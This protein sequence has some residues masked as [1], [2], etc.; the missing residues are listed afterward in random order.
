MIQHKTSLLLTALFITLQVS[1]MEAQQL[2]QFAL[3]PWSL[4]EM[5]PAATG[6]GEDLIFNGA[7]RRQWNALPGSPSGYHINA[8]MP[9][10]AIRSGLGISLVQDQIGLLNNLEATVL[11]GYHLPV[12][13][14]WTIH[15]G[16]AA[17]LFQSGLDGSGIRTPDGQ[18][19]DNGGV[20]HQDDRLPVDQVNALSPLLHAGVMVS[21]DQWT[22]GTS[23]RYAQGGQLS[24][25]GSTVGTELNIQPHIVFH[26][27][28]QTE[29]GALQ[30]RPTTIWMSDLTQ[31]QVTTQCYLTWRERFVIA[32]GYRGWSGSSQDAFIMTAG[33]H[34]SDRF[35]MMYA[36][37]S[38]LSPLKQTHN[39]SFELMIQYRIPTGLSKGKLPGIIYNPR[40]L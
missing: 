21:S 28:W 16:V 20:D 33:V 10:P 36:Y 15:G 6:A 3:T 25:S 17:G 32:G 34:V 5:N 31:I 30:V 29:L 2:P 4:V 9:F 38:G 8:H 37:E 40:F 27:S 12:S 1:V 39:G 18:Y 7:A 22:F 24:Y 26:A 23:L 13:R 19:P 35:L 14:D 11:Y